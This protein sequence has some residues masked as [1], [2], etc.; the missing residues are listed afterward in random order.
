[1]DFAATAE[2]CAPEVAIDTLRRIASVESSFNPFAIGVVG[3]RLQRQPRTLSE[4]LATTRMLDTQGYDYSLGIVQIH[5]KNFAKYGLTPETAFDPCVNLRVGSQI[6]LDCYKR[7]GAS[8][9]T[10]GDALS[11]YHSGN[12]ATGYRLGYV[13][14]VQTA[15]ALDPGGLGPGLAG[16][17][18]PAAVPKLRQGHAQL[19][20]S[21]FVTQAR[22][23]VAVIAQAG[24][25]PSV[26]ESRATALI[27]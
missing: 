22:S 16:P 23:S 10:L 26:T 25:P 7:A 27:F 3:G 6:F 12:F 2:L 14:K 9:H 1:M 19:P 18:Q 21:L 20:Q 13:A 4:A 11:C 17:R 24:E 5:Q 8:V 15:N